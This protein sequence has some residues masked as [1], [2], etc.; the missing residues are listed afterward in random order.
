M[1]TYT[2]FCV[3]GYPL[4]SSKSAVV[5][6]AMTVFRE[7]DKRVFA[8]DLGSR[9]A[10]IWGDAYSD[11]AGQVETATEY[12][13]DTGAVVARLE[14]MG[15]T[16][17]RARREFEAG[18]QAELEMYKE[19]AAEEPDATWFID[20]VEVLKELSFDEY[21]VALKMVIAEGLRP[22]PFDDCGRTG[23]ST[24]VKYVLEDNEEYLF[25]FFTSD[26]R[27]LIRVACEVAQKPSEVAQ[28]I[29]DLIDG[30]YYDSNDSVCKQSIDSLTIGHLENA[31]RIVLTEGV[32]DT[33]VLKASLELL[34]PHLAGYYSFLDF[35]GTRIPGGA[36][37]LASLVKGFAGAGI[38]NRIIAIFD[39]DSAARDAIR[40]LAQLRLPS[41]IA[42][43][44][45]PDIDLL[46]SYPTLGPSGNTNLDVNGLAA[47]IELYLGV[48][49]LARDDGSLAPVQW[50]GYVEAVA[51]YQGEVLGKNELHAA[52]VRKVAAARQDSSAVVQQDW[53]GIDTILRAIFSA[54]R[55]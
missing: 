31:N 4:I 44:R 28:D 38:G 20:K 2:D 17:T 30:G 21:L 36:G 49:V 34:Y 13:C 12:A 32:T 6:E 3:A 51:G 54:F 48:D 19:W 41:N 10:L 14:I 22:S 18:R 37:Q 29:T 53:S 25:G 33:V 42:V 50:K 26:V 46:R 40:S 5:P 55:D 7:E 24:A 43:L 15:F 45:Y 47:S 23:L 1:G 8:R 11:D 35:G 27:C 39:N 52:F 9:N 16:L